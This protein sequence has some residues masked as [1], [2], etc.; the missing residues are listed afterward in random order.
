MHFYLKCHL[1]LLILVFTGSSVLLAQK[2]DET[3]SFPHSSDDRLQIELFAENPQIVMP[4]GIDVDE[5][6][7]VWAIESNTHFPPEGYHR[8]DSDWVLVLSDQNGDG[9]ADEI[10]IFVEGVT[11]QIRS[12][13]MVS[14]SAG[15]LLEESA[16]AV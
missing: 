3:K 11:D 1:A 2:T 10:V 15:I 5:C 13:A 8:A 16:E 9:K 4:T 6:S 12:E 7:R 14:L